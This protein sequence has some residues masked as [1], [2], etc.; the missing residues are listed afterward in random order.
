MADAPIIR[1]LLAKRGVLPKPIKL[2]EPLSDDLTV[3]EIILLTV[4][5]AAVGQR[6]GWGTAKQSERHLAKAISVA[7]RA[8][9]AQ[10]DIEAAVAA[11]REED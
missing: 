11:G 5:D 7:R 2:G 10:D 4:Y 8:G 6:Q 9:F 3:N 1:Q